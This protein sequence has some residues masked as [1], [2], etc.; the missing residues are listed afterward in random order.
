MKNYSFIGNLDAKCAWPDLIQLSES[1][2]QLFGHTYEVNLLYRL[3]YFNI[4]N[5][6]S[7]LIERNNMHG[8]KKHSEENT[9]SRG[10]MN[11]YILLNVVNYGLG[12]GC[13]KVFSISTFLRMSR[14]D[15]TIKGSLEWSAIL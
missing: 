13:F 6:L 7:K 11:I 9:V 5:C 10:R 2:H 12:L 4:F 3:F 15:R 1:M 8:L 14:R